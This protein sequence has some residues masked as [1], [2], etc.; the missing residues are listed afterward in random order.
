MT[1]RPHQIPQ[2]MS[3]LDKIYTAYTKRIALYP[4]EAGK[5]TFVISL[6]DYMK[7]IILYKNQELFYSLPQGIENV[8]I[9]GYCLYMGMRILYSPS[10]STG[11]FVIGTEQV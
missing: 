6:H 4:N 7:D 1:I 8:N 3:I 11:E 5:C 10:L 2:Q 9:G